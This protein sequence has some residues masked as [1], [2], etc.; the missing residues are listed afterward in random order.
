MARAALDEIPAA[1]LVVLPAGNPYQKGRAPR[2]DG[3]ARLA[4][5]SLAFAGES[6]VMLDRRELDRHGPTYTIDTV[7]EF[8]AE[9][10]GRPLIWLI[11]GDAFAR[12]DT[13]HCWRELIERVHFAV[14]ARAGQE[15][16]AAM[17]DSLAA[18]FAG[19]WTDAARLTEA[20]AGGACALLAAHPPAISSTA[21]RETIARG[22]TARGLVPDAVCD[23]IEQHRL[24]RFQ[25]TNQ[26]G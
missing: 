15:V 21:V 2:A 14:V 22:G 26:V 25:E 17:S 1:D 12:L 8:R 4:M 20:E 5:L 19:R 18:A 7:D 24:Y 16:S 10:G 9:Q 23:Y 3:A 6:R 13:W 11:G